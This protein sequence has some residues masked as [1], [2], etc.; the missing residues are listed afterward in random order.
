MID[1]LEAG[2]V[3]TFGPVGASS[4]WPIM[5]GTE[6][7]QPNEIIVLYDTPGTAPNPKFLLE[8][9]RFKVVVRATRYDEAYAK[10]EEIKSHLLG[11]P[12]QDIN[13]IRYVGIYGVMD[14]F[15]LKADQRGRHVFV[16]TWR[17][18]REPLVGEHRQPL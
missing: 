2:G 14:T 7:D 13:G 17:T 15:H 11:L 6:P 18:I 16:N 12:S 9:P 5:I 4:L 10:A 8:Y 3:G 1:L